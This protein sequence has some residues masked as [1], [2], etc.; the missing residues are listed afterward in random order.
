MS[1][2]FDFFCALHYGEAGLGS[3]AMERARSMS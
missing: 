1:F 3:P 2:I